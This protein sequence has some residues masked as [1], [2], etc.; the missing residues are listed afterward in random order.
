[1]IDPSK[2]SYV[3]D[4]ESNLLATQQRISSVLSTISKRNNWEWNGTVG[5]AP[6]KSFMKDALT[7]RNGIY[8]YFGHGAGE[9]FFSRSNVEELTNECQSSIILMGCSS[10]N[11]VSVNSP[12]NG[13]IF[14]T[15][16]HFEPDGAALSYLCAGAPCVV[17]NL[18]DVTDRDIDRFSISLLEGIFQDHLT[19]VAQNVSSS[20][21]ACKLKYIV[22]CAPVV[23]GIPVA[24]G[25][26]SS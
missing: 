8:L 16:M 20:R 21:D 24:V 2:T 12:K 26:N 4:P 1:M 25:C 3:L 5:I 9:R 14:D 15:E 7:E 6:S 17:S 23:Y 18:W 13:H 22:G 11:L 19:N 10:G